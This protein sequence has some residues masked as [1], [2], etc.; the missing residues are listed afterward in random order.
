MRKFQY[1]CVIFG[2]IRGLVCIVL[3]IQV[4]YDVVMT[5]YWIGSYEK[6]KCVT[7]S[8]FTKLKAIK[9]G[10]NDENDHERKRNY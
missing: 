4:K 9:N 10:K 6:S 7:R 8:Y 1:I 2:R 3:K 5:Q